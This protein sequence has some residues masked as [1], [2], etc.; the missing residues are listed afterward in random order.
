MTSSE[1]V[2]SV[3]GLLFFVSGGVIAVLLR[4]SSTAARRWLACVL[5]AYVLL[6]V[7]AVAELLAWPLTSAYEP[8][9][10][11]SGAPQPG[12]IVVL[13]GGSE[14]VRGW[15]GVAGTLPIASMQRVL[16]AARVYRE[17]GNPWVISSGGGRP[18]EEMNLSVAAVMRRELIDQGV[19]A[20]RI[21]MEPTSR[22]TRE[23]VAPTVAALRQLGVDRFVLVTSDTHMRRSVATFRAGG[24]D[25]I[26]AIAPHDVL[27][28]WLRFVPSNRG[29]EFDGEVFHEYVGLLYYAARGWI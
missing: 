16:E 27:N 8:F 12:A 7:H 14:T 1:F 25:A 23:E 2:F 29:L 5:A 24:A 21:V 3:T 26:P 13:G 22:S 6:S 11:P 9:E 28:G 15:Q 17:L 19:P 4:P 18:G 10:R 20:D